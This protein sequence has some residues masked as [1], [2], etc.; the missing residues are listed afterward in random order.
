MLSPAEVGTLWRCSVSINKR[1]LSCHSNG[2]V[3]GSSAVTNKLLCDTVLTVEI[4]RSIS[5]VPTH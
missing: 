5:L 2:A 4:C 1:V 3:A